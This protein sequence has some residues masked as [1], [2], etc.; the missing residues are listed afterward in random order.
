[1]PVSIGSGAA[2]S[3]FRLSCHGPSGLVSPPERIRDRYWISPPQA[4]VRAY[5]RLG[6]SAPPV[7]AL[8]SFPPHKEAA[9]SEVLF[10]TSAAR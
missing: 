3:G 4:L 2:L 8:G 7:D 5:H 9:G 10:V 6:S 1:M